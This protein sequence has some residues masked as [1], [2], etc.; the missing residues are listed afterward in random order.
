MVLGCV[1]FSS[2]R[3]QRYF[4]VGLPVADADGWGRSGMTASWAVLVRSGSDFLTIF[5]FN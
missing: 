1:G 3:E 5:T 4:L 2:G